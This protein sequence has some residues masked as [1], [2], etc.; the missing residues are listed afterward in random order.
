MAATVQQI[1]IFAVMAVVE[2]ATVQRIK[3]MVATGNGREGKGAA[4][5][6]VSDRVLFYKDD[7]A[8]HL[9]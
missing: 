6:N 4:Y 5:R 2:N 9:C 7:R 8:V 1:T 3:I